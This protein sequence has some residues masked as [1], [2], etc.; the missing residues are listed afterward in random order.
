MLE[1]DLACWRMIRVW[2]FEDD[3][4]DEPTLTEQQFR[5]TQ[6]PVAALDNLIQRPSSV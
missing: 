4:F 3:L 6:P 5:G 2:N 1:F